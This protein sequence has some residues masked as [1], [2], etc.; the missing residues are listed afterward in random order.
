MNLWQKN[1]PFFMF[2]IKF[3]VSYL[4]L[5]VLYW[6]YLSGYDTTKYETDSITELVA[7]QSAKASTLL[8]EEAYVMPHL[9][10]A[11]YRFYIKNESVARI[12]EGCNAVSVIILFAAF[13][14]AFSTT[15]KKT[16]SFILA[17]IL[18]IHILNILRI[19]LLSMGFYYYPEYEELMHDILFPLF[20]YG[21]VFA[22][23]VL[24]VLKLSGN[25]EKGKA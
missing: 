11:S 15:F 20:I 2:L 16:T 21:V 8:G 4:L 17:G 6:L 13:I 9:K 12:A 22:L 23:W 3:G 14:I 25:A 19:A 24:W 18:I 10:E 5:S 1:R 7:K